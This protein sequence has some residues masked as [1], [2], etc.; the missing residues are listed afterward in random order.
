MIDHYRAQQGEYTVRVTDAKSERYTQHTTPAQDQSEALY[1]RYN[2]THTV[3]NCRLLTIL[4][5]LIE[6]PVTVEQTSPYAYAT[7]GRAAGTESV[8]L[9][10]QHQAS[11]CTATTPAAT[12]YN[13]QNDIEGDYA[14]IRV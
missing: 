6:V 4:N 9:Q 13:I 14:V 7:S 1:D 10:R 3:I 12:V 8:P 11:K 2:Y 5:R